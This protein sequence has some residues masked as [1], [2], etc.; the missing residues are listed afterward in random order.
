MLFPLRDTGF[1]A[2]DE[3]AYVVKVGMYTRRMTHAA[4]L[5]SDQ[6][7]ETKVSTVLSTN[8]NETGHRPQSNYAK[9]IRSCQINFAD[10][11]IYL[12]IRRAKARVAQESCGLRRGMA[13]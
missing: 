11:E 8:S 2:L 10:S 1:V 6:G 9:F 12:Q 7:L 13:D 4:P 5:F 3:A